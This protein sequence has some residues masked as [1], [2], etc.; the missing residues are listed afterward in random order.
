MRIDEGQDEIV[1]LMVSFVLGGRIDGRIYG[2]GPG[3]VLPL[4]R[5]RGH[6]GKC[7]DS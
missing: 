6:A 3:Y 2:R 7:N 1:I 5:K 4:F